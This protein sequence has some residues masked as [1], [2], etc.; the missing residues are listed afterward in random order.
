MP[1]SEDEETGLG[2][3]IFVNGNQTVTNGNVFTHNKARNGSAIYTDGDN[4]RLHNDVFYENQAWSYLLVITAVPPESL[5]HSQD[6]EINVVHRAGDNIINAIHNRASP[7]EVHFRNVTF[8]HSNGNTITTDSTRYVEPVDGVENS[9]EGTLL[10][11]DDREDYQLIQL[12][13]T[14]EDGEIFYQNTTMITNI[15]GNVN[16]TLPRNS[17]RKGLYIVDAEHVEDWNYKFIVNATTF[18]ILDA[19]DVS[20]NKTSDADEYFQ[21]EIAAWNITVTNAGN[22]TDAEYVT[23]TDFL[24]DTF[25]LTSLNFTFYNATNGAWTNGTLYLNNSTLSYGVY[26]K[27]GGNWIYGDANYDPSTNTWKY[28]FF[29][30]DD[31]TIVYTEFHEE[32]FT[33]RF[34]QPIFRNSSLICY[35]NVSYRID[36]EEWYYETI[37]VDGQEIKYGIF[38]ETHFTQYFG[39]ARYDAENKS[40]VFVK[41]VTDPQSGETTELY[42]WYNETTGYWII[43]YEVFAPERRTLTQKVNLTINE[44]PSKNLTHIILGVRDFDKSNTA[45]VLFETNCTKAGTYNNIVNV[46]TPDYDWDLS[47]NE[48]NKT[49]LVD[50]LPNKTVSN[51]TPY[52]GDFVEYNLTIKNTG[53]ET[54]AHDLI[55]IDSLP[56][57]LEYNETVAIIGADQVGETIVD[58]QKITW[59]V[60]NIT[61]F[62]NATIIVKVRVHALG[63][64]TNNMT[65]VAPSGFNRTVNATITPVDFTDVYVNK[66]VEKEEYFVDDIVIWTITV[67]VAN[68]GSN[69]TNVTLKDILPSE[70]EFINASIGTYDNVTGVLEI[71]FME[72]GTSVTLTITSRA[73]IVANN[74]TNNA[75]VNC[76]ETE[77]DYDN[78]FDNATIDILPNINKTANN[79]APDYHEYVDYNLT[80]INEGDNVYA[81][82][83]TVIDSLPDG[84][85]YNNTVGIYGAVQVGDVVQDGQ[86]ITW[87]VTNIAAHTNATIVVRVRADAIGTLVNNYTLIGP[88]GSNRT[89]NETIVVNPVVDISVNKTVER[90]EYKVNETV[91]WTI[92]VY[93]ANNGTNATNVL[94]KDILPK[95]VE[96]VSYTATNG[97]YDNETKLRSTTLLTMLL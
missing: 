62:T 90:D 69:A 31:D 19:M 91:V 38:N 64:L 75:T 5:Y 56:E 1:L 58:G 9:Q 50:P 89:V 53:N 36:N 92:T 40:W 49:V 23:I 81:D 28:Y 24:P 60:T 39:N 13:V 33:D 16:V 20:I 48:D 30:M 68:N 21:D 3:A 83:L 88:K 10:Y 87:R 67:S 66:S 55:V 93:N 86:V 41:N 84:L 43:G 95:E 82:V 37:T 35:D 65:L 94:L 80:I 4:F 97:T 22:G 70:V 7:D 32:D 15:Y 73:K 6:V 26:N 85:V 54:Y 51:S 2:G 11:Q 27:S 63:N 8:V 12:K 18:R 57:G 29:E 76:T 96:F 59:T 25:N 77:W 42:T 79:T 17:L 14:H 45:V 52:Y 72:N 46:T 71:G 78:N 61:A 44:E 74:V 34:G 47:N